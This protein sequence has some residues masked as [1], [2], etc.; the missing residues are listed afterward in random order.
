MKEVITW[1]MMISGVGCLLINFSWIGYSLYLALRV[2]HRID[3][4][5]DPVAYEINL[6]RGDPLIS[7]WYRLINYSGAASFRWLNRRTLPWYDMCELPDK[8][9]TRLT[10]HYWGLLIG[11]FLLIT[12]YLAILLLEN[13]FRT[14]VQ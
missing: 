10:I 5:I 3:E 13:G 2:V 6:L 12:G 11:V 4:I 14:A 8:L 9:R 1:Y 7:R